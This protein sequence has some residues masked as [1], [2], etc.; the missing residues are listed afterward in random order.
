MGFSGFPEAAL[1]FYD[2]LEADN[3]KSFWQAHRTTYEKAVRAPMLEL[4]GALEKEFG[5]AKVF[6]PHRDG[7]FVKHCFYDAGTNL[8]RRAA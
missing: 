4:T 5:E 3:S 6:R 7:C 2:D 8:V 1:D